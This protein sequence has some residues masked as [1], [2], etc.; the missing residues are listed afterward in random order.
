MQ[1]VQAPRLWSCRAPGAD[2]DAQFQRLLTSA[3]AANHTSEGQPGPTANRQPVSAA[4]PLT[5]PQRPEGGRES[6]RGRRTH[7]V[8]ATGRCA[9]RKPYFLFVADSPAPTSRPP[10]LDP[11][12][13]ERRTAVLQGAESA[14]H[15]GSGSKLR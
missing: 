12:S 11:S 2:A 8:C 10:S 14:G 13:L 15:A 1:S 4:N 6:R 3:A 7:G 9:L 5:N